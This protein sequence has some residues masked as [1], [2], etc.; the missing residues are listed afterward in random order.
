ME[1]ATV[2][3]V[4]AKDD[5]RTCPKCGEKNPVG[6]VTCA[7]CKEKLFRPGKKSKGAKSVRTEKVGKADRR[8]IEKRA[9]GK[10]A[11]KKPTRKQG[12]GK[13]DRLRQALKSGKKEFTPEE[14]M[15]ASDFDSV[16]L[17]VALSILRNPNRT[18]KERMIHTHFDPDK[19]VFV[20]DRN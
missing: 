5:G 2:K 18:P 1:Q 7:K 10:K 13:F 17:R 15:K 3:A 9:K 14:L 19:K 20:L 6:R 11:E 12:N 4:E 16:N 8:R